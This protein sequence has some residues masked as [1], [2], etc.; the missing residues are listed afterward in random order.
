MYLSPEHENDHTAVD[1]VGVCSDSAP[2]V[3]LTSRS[4]VHAFRGAGQFTFPLGPSKAGGE[5]SAAEPDQGGL[6]RFAGSHRLYPTPGSSFAPRCR[7]RSVARWAQISRGQAKGSA[8]ESAS[9]AKA[10]G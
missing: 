1:F 7:V 6:R 8:R 10:G 5:L 4:C 2:R 3:R 9:S